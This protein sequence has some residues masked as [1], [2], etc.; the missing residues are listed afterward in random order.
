MF[1]VHARDINALEG[2]LIASKMGR[3]RERESVL[4]YKMVNTFFP[5]TGDIETLFGYRD[6]FWLST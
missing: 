3:Q 2:S 1:V 4:K 6:T 5:I